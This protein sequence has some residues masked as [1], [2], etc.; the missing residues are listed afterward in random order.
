MD[1]INIISESIKRRLE[2]LAKFILKYF[3]VYLPGIIYSL[4]ILC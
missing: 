2:K 4:F 1:P 3:N